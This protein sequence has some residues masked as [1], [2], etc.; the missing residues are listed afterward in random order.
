MLDTVEIRNKGPPRES[1][2]DAGTAMEGRLYAVLPY[3][4]GE[5]N[6]Y[7][8]GT[9]ADNSRATGS[10][11]AP[12]FHIVARLMRRRHAWLLRASSRLVTPGARLLCAL[13][14]SCWPRVC[15]RP[16]RHPCGPYR[17]RRPAIWRFLHRGGQLP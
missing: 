12:D 6:P 9:G 4:A 7:R 15:G 11:P 10:C 14:P 2:E 17:K 13:P 8:F 5:L 3:E 16:K 1:R